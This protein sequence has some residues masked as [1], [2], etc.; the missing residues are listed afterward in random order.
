MVDI[1]SEKDIR[2][3]LKKV[4]H[5]VVQRSLI[6]LGIIKEI[7]VRDDNVM[8]TLAFPFIGKPADH[9]TTRVK[10]LNSV[11]EQVE[12][13]G[14]NVRLKQAQMNREEFQAFLAMERKTWNDMK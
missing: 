2:N 6:D 5:P 8:I 10:I 14:M 7:V 1:I 4:M 12:V 3:A 11:R 9:I 13:L